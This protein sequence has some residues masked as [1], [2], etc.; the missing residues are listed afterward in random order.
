[1]LSILLALLLFSTCLFSGLF[2]AV[3]P[4]V[5]CKGAWL[6]EEAEKPLVDPWPTPAELCKHRGLLYLAATFSAS[7][8][9]GRPSNLVFV[10]I[11][12][13]ESVELP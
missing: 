10:F 1:M 8:F 3:V 2:G 7:R 11:L 9:S 4:A 5:I 6:D 13:G 12:F